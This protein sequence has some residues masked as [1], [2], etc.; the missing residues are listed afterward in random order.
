MKETNNPV[1]LH[2]VNAVAALKRFRCG[3][4]QSEEVIL[5]GVNAVAALKPLGMT[6]LAVR[7]EDSPRRERR[8]RIEAW[9]GARCGR[10]G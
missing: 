3:A 7:F 2:G 5:H 10:R 1:I 9:P 8:G 4:N 6:T